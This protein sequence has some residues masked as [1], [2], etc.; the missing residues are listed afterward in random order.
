[1]NWKSTIAYWFAKRRV[2][3][4]YH[5]LQH[6]SRIQQQMLKQ[7][8][9]LAQNT[10]FGKTHHFERIQSI[11]DFQK[12]VPVRSYEDLLPYLE[13]IFN[14]ESN[15]LWRGKPIYFAKTSG[16]TAGAKYIPITRDSAP[17]LVKGAR[18]ALLLYTY[19]HPETTFWDGK[20]LFLSGSPK[21]ERHESGIPVGRL[22]GIA[23]H[24]V[25]KYLQKNRLPPYEINCIEDWESKVEAIIQYAIYQD[26]RLISGIPPWVQMF[27]ERL[28]QITGKKP[29]EVWR[30]LQVYVY[31]GVDFTPYQP[32]F[33]KYFDERVG[34]IETF[35]ASEGF[36]AIG[37]GKQRYEPMLL[38]PDYGVFYEFIPLEAYYKPNPPRLTIEAVRCNVDYA[39]VITTNAGLWAYDLGDVIRF[40]SLNPPKIRVTGRVKHF[41]SAF[42]EHVIEAEVIKAVEAAAKA[43][44][45]LIQEFS[46]APVVKQQQG[47]HEWFIEFIQLPE[48]MKKFI[49]VLDTTLRAANPYYEDLRSGNL[50]TLPKVRQLK[51]GA[52]RAYMKAQGKLGGQNKFPHLKNDRSIA[53]FF[54]KK[55]WI[56]Q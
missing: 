30:N 16:T 39:I 46:V 29:L 56:L 34:M 36:F 18:D 38:M 17:F 20:M 15:V 4:I 1:M 6:F 9:R 55:G 51:L 7:F 31:G 24:L 8:V 33:Q 42:G 3:H 25:P 14:G 52:C 50:L 13:R 12:Q 27:F 43:T 48:D 35:P 21:L 44:N 41:L 28:E 19:H 53:Q 32:I 47:Y 2:K 22:S 23:H 26:L 10:Y 40:V 11:E 45:A 5:Q 49:E 54:E 37:E